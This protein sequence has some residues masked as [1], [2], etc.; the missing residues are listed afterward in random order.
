MFVFM[1]IHLGDKRNIQ[2]V[3]FSNR[4]GEETGSAEQ[5]VDMFLHDNERFI[6]TRGQYGDGAA[7]TPQS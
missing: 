3:I 2:I 4:R 6:V 1:F 5:L 7:P